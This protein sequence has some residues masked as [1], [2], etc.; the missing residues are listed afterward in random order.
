MKEPR[1]AHD[2]DDD[3]H[4]EPGEYEPPA[5]AVLG[6]LPEL[7]PGDSGGGSDGTFPGSIIG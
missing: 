2:D 4:C 6:S 7:T 3:A 1:M 5:I